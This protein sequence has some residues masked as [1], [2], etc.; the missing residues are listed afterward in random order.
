MTLSVLSAPI[1]CA[2]Y[3]LIAFP[4]A[5]IG[6]TTI[7]SILIAAEKPART[8][9]P[10]LFTTLCTSIIPIDTVDCWRIDGRAMSEIVFMRSA[11]QSFSFFSSNSERV[12]ISMEN[13]ITAEIP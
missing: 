13:E 6:T 9:E 2:V 8:S 12:F 3:E 10:K 1:F 5:D 11:D 4:I 7:L